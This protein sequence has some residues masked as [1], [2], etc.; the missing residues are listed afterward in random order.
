LFIFSL[1]LKHL[2]THIRCYTHANTMKKLCI[3]INQ[4]TKNIPGSKNHQTLARLTPLLVHRTKES[5][6]L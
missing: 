4:E 6:Y 5:Q 2:T 1:T 3:R